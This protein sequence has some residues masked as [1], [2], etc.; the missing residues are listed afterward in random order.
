M[1]LAVGLGI[2]LVNGILVTRLSLPPVIATLVTAIAI[3]GLDAGTALGPR[4]VVD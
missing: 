1:T 2:G 3:V 4:R